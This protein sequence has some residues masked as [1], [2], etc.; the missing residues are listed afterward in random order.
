MARS[1]LAQILERMPDYVIDVSQ[2]E[3]YPHQGTNTGFQ[4]IPAR[5]TPGP[6]R[7]SEAD[8]V[9]QMT[10]RLSTSGNLRSA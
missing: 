1:L 6:R 3:A 5:F 4:R 8:Q 7:L 9:S 10:R 2:L